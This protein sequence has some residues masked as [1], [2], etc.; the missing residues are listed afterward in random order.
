MIG[1]LPIVCG[2]SLTPLAM[3]Q[4][5]DIGFYG[6]CSLLTPPDSLL[7]QL[8]RCFNCFRVCPQVQLPP[9]RLWLATNPE[10]AN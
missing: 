5:D 4:F 10:Q 9:Q 7:L 3:L 6:L 2:K 1:F 8:D